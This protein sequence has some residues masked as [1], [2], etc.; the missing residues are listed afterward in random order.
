VLAVPSI[1]KRVIGRT[2]VSVTAMGFGGVGLGQRIGV[3]SEAQSAATLGAALEAAS[4]IS[5][6]HPGTG[7]A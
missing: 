7:T 4:N 1:E 5:T 2:G 6:H 3:I